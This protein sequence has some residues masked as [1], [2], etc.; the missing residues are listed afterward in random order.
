MR[1]P[2]PPTRYWQAVTLADTRKAHSAGRHY[3]RAAETE[4]TPMK[5]T[6]L[7]RAFLD[8]AKRHGMLFQ[9]LQMAAAPIALLNPQ[10]E[11]SWFAETGAEIG[12]AAGQ[13]DLA[14]KWVQTANVQGRPGGSLDHWLALADIADPGLADRGPKP[15]SA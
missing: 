15:A 8:D 12:L 11:I 5:K 4:Q 7:I 1:R 14:R 6:R 2:K 10:P 3:S 9:A 13:Y